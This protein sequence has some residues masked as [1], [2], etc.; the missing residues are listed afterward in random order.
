MFQ[1]VAWLVYGWAFLV[2]LTNALLMR[3]PNR[4]G[5]CAL[6][7]MVP[8]RD[9][10]ERL[11]HLLPQLVGQGCPVTVYDDHSSDGTGQLARELG[12]VVVTGSDLPPGWRGKPHACH[13]LAQLAQAEWVVFLDADTRPSADFV[14][15]LSAFLSS[16]PESTQVV[17]GFPKMLP[18]AGFEPV[19]LFWVPWILLATNPFGLVARTGIGHNMFLNGQVIAWRLST[20]QKLKP[21]EQIKG[22]VL[23]DVMLGRLLARQGIKVEVANLS[24]ILSVKMYDSLHDALEGMKKNT[25]DVVPGRYGF[26]VFALVLL[27]LSTLW[28]IQ[29]WAGLLGL[30]SALLVNSVVRMPIYAV[31]AWPLSLIS[32]SFTSITSGMARRRGSVSWKGRNL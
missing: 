13:R 11:P 7:V 3:R 9:E 24:S 23:D 12:A 15:R 21:Y 26:V 20:L 14:D 10:A 30:A 17:T 5:P 1:A 19:Y 25:A 16:R 27:G 29:P 22:E 6:E 8:A 2:A 18:G 32:G 31:V 28:L 4:S